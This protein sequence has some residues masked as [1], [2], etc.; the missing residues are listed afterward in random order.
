MFVGWSRSSF[1]IE[2]EEY[3]KD[4]IVDKNLLLNTKEYD[5][6]HLF[7]IYDCK[8][9]VAMISAYE[10]ENSIQ[11]NNFYY[12]SVV[13]DAK[14]S[15]LISLLLS[16][17]DTTK[18]IYMIV[19]KEEK[20][21]FENFGFVE[22]FSVDRAYYK[23]ESVPFNFSE[24]MAKSVNT[25]EYLPLIKK[26]SKKL[27]F[28]DRSEYV[29]HILAKKSSLVLSNTQ[30]YQHSYALDKNIIKVS[31]WIMKSE[32]FDDCEKMLRGLLYY[33]GLKHIVAFIPQVDVIKEL[34]TNY[35]FTIEKSHSLIYLNSKLE[36]NLDNIYAF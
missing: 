23:G 22:Q 8:K 14:K 35:K 16:N 9:L 10:F 19:K 3:S 36:T 31:P 29:T 15:E 4:D 32:S 28:D 33:R 18:P 17:L 34:Y 13:D 5:P 27:F 30:G 6:S 2:L 21:L 12:K 1:A 24:A 26:Y 7:C 11:I 25:E 20:N